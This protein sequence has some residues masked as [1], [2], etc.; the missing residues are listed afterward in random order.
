MVYKA[1]ETAMWSHDAS[2]EARFLSG[3]QDE[4]EV[5]VNKSTNKT[6]SAATDQA[7]DFLTSVS[8][9]IEPR[10]GRDASPTV[11]DETTFTEEEREG[12]P[13]NS[14]R[15]QTAA[16]HQWTGAWSSSGN[17]KTISMC[18]PSSTTLRVAPIDAYVSCAAPYQLQP[19]FKRTTTIQLRSDA[20]SF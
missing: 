10:L 1:A 9:L 2:L 11:D 13:I 20:L 15:P 19:R 6:S 17:H 8:G 18:P 5:V 7:S 4:V 12:P 14:R 16:S 3:S